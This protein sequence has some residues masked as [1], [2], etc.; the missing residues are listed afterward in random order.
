MRH[1][2]CY[3]KHMRA[4]SDTYRRPAALRRH[5]THHII[6]ALIVVA[7]VAATALFLAYADWKQHQDA[8]ALQ[9]AQT[10]QFAKLDADVKAALAAKVEKPARRKQKQRRKHSQPPINQNRRRRRKLRRLLRSVT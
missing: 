8:A 1:F 9:A 10:K 3:N 5:R 4:T 2:H 6:T 7:L